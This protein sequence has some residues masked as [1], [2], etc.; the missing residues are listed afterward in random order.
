[1]SQD[2]ANYRLAMKIFAD[3]SGT[4]AIPAVLAAVAGK[5]LDTLYHTAPRYQVVL[6]AFALLST[7]LLIYK[8]AKKYRDEYESI[9]KKPL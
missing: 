6:L 4:I 1:M 5:K 7:A 8:K 3:F 9:N 2:S